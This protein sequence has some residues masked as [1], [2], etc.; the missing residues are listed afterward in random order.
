MDTSE[1]N[2]EKKL[3]PVPVKE[4]AKIPRREE[5]KRPVAERIRDKDEIY[6]KFTE[7]EVIEQASR[8]IECKVPKCMNDGCPLHNRIPDWL[9]L[10]AAGDFAAAARLSNETSNLPEICGRVCPQYKLCEGHC[11]LS[12]KQ[13]AVAIGKI[14]K[15]INDWVRDHGGLPVPEIPPPTGFR[16]ACVGAGPAGLAAADELR[17]KGHEVTVFDKKAVAG[18]L[19]YYGIPPFKLKKSVVKARVERLEKMGVTFVLGTEIGKEIP[20]TVLREKHGFDAVFVGI[21]APLCKAARCEG[22]DLG[23]VFTADE[24]LVANNVPKPDR[25]HGMDEDIPLGKSVI[26]FGGGNTAMDC[27][28]TAV[29]QGYEKVYCFYRRSQVEMPAG[30]KE[31]INAEEEGVQFQYL[32]APSRFLPNGGTKVA[33]VECFRMDL[34]EPDES[35]RRRPVKVEGSE[36]TVDVDT[37]VLAIGYDNDLAFG[38]AVPDLKVDK[39]GCFL[40]DAETGR[41][42][43]PWLFAGGDAVHGADLVVTAVAAGRR[44]AAGIEA[45]LTSL[46]SAS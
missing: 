34:G 15:F 45:Y 39:W 31:R 40:V 3:N 14:E 35:G 11:S 17:K 28:R 25:P 5:K 24:F 22:E 46:K 23:R 43:V 10:V 13:G 41:T 32:V 33:K 30:E 27:V 1:V 26:I 42:S 36:F 18:G 20:L 2:A 19:L 6:I 9:R 38:S 44:A 8:C 21:G 37:I 12:K 16:V 4:R 7:A 29:R